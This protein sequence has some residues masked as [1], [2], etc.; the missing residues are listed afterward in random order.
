MTPDDFV[1]FPLKVSP[2]VHAFFKKRS[3]ETGVA[4]TSLMYLVLEDYVKNELVLQQKY[5]EEI[6]K[7][8]NQQQKEV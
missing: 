3:K 5:G 7:I 8:I 1:R 2:Q 4:M 6:A